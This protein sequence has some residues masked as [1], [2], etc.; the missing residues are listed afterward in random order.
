MLTPGG[1]LFSIEPIRR[2]FDIARWHDL[3]TQAGITTGEAHEFY[4]MPIG[5][6]EFEQHTLVMG[7][8]P[9]LSMR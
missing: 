1:W 3:L 6:K 7:Q 2:G 5:Q 9:F 4:R 8:K